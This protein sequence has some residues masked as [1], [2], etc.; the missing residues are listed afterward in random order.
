MSKSAILEQA[1]H[2]FLSPDS[3]GQLQAI[4]LLHHHAN[5]RSLSRLERDLAISTELM[6]TLTRFFLMITPLLP[7]AE[8]AAATA[9]GRLR[10]EQVIEEVA[11]RVRT[12]H[13]LMER[14]KTTLD[15]AT[16]QTSTD[17]VGQEADRAPSASHSVRSRPAQSDRD[18]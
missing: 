16:H 18:G 11:R 17:T 4:P 3:T 10:F 7:E 15:Q 8:Q 6:A 1:L 12:D 13:S 9:L 2:L 14:V 5:A